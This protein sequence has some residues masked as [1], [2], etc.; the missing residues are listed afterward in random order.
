MT[1]LHPRP[2]P[3]GTWCSPLSA[4]RVALAGVRVSAPRVDAGAVYWVESRPAEGGRHVIVRRSRDGD[5][6]DVT[7][8]GF[9]ARSRVHEYGGGAYAVHGATVYFTNQA[10][11]RVYRQRPGEDPAPLTAAG[12]WRH[13]DLTFDAAGQRLLCVRE[14]LSADLPE[15]R[16]AVVSVRGDAPGDDPGRVLAA[17]PAFHASPRLSPDG[18]QLAWLTWDHPDMPWDAS[19]LWLAELDGAGLPQRPQP[20][21]GGAGE[22]IVQPEWGLDGSLYFVSD[23]SGWWNL[24]RWQGGSVSVVA[25]MEAEFGVPPWLFGMSTYAVLADGS[26]ACAYTR[27]GTWHLAHI[28][29]VQQRLRTLQTPW[30]ALA[31]LQA[32]RQAVVCVAASPQA[33]AAVVRLDPL[34]G[35]V[36]GLRPVSPPALPPEWIAPP[37]SIEFTGTGGARAYALYY[38][39]H[40]PD[41]TGPAGERPPLLVRCHGGPTAAAAP[42]LDPVVQFWT[43]RGF[44]LVDVNYG[45]STGYGRRYRERLDG[46]WGLVDVEDCIAAARHLAERGDVDARRMAIRGS[47]AGGFTALS[48]LAF[49]DVFQAGAVYYGISDLESLVHDTHKFESHYLHRLVGP[50]P[51]A[52]DTYRVRSPLL[53]ADRISAPVIFFQGL[54]DRVVPPD[55]TER[56]AAAL[57]ARGIPVEYL[58]FPGEQHGFR[59]AETVRRC[60]EAE[61]A[62]YS[63]V[64]RLLPG[65]T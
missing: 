1:D 19:V 30:T 38:R 39:P 46:C 13:A 10:D 32:D 8:S 47:S 12:P 33:D 53:H 17:G 25:P 29:P 26:L 20:L 16:S 9:S 50:H 35:R 51:A 62:F 21:A 58:A 22:S 7:P 14:E 59:Q 52:S 18:R 27:S 56:M 15:P 34:N 44:A 37:E 28:D 49:H 5:T 63:R 43:T 60:L 55:Q 24:Y 2:A 54:E 3:F 41:Y 11:Q 65:E 23:R 64:F 4:E 57:R 6:T 48:A 40:N 45:G 31:D 61:L 42:V 36:E